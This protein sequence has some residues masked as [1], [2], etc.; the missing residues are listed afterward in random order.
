MTTDATS[1]TS[2]HGRTIV[3]Y[4]LPIIALAVAIAFHISGLSVDEGMMSVRVLVGAIS[5][6]IMFVTVFVVLHH[7]EAV[8]SR[9][10]EPYGTLVLTMAV[11]A[12]EVSIIV[13]MML[14]GA[15]NPTLARES[16]FSTVMIT[17]TGVVGLCLTLGGW[18]HRKQAIL[19]QGTSAYLAVLIALTV[20]TLIL[21]TYTVATGPGTF[22]T[23]QLAFVSILSV[24]L[25][26]GFVF[27]QTVRLRDDFVDRRSRHTGAEKQAEA[28]EDIT[29]N[30]VLMLAGLIGIV[31]LAEQVA[32][33]IEN[34]L[35]SFQVSQA[36]AIVGSLIAGLVLLPEAVSAIRAGLNNELQRGLNVAM[37][38]ACATIGLTIPA[39][40]FASLITGRGLT[41]GLPASDAVL[42]NSGTFCKHRK[43]WD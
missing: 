14:H 13:S 11:T 22:S 8:A 1:I 42:F 27:A 12:I 5:S 28:P 34:A 9:L 4:G 38:S 15:N 23:A 31:M 41:L 33:S 21:P 29:A 26:A 24:L 7:A 39:V 20:L 36:D 30:V 19:R 6:A 40:A 25:Y 10:G 3:S 43:F 17:S 37:G 35:T 32:G 2:A 16:V 18:K